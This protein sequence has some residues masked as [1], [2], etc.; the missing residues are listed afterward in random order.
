[1][2]GHFWLLFFCIFYYFVDDTFINNN[3]MLCVYVCVLVLFGQQTQNVNNFISAVIATCNY[4][5]LLLID[6]LQTFSFF[7]C[8]LFFFDNETD[9]TRPSEDFSLTCIGQNSHMLNAC[10]LSFTVYTKNIIIS[11]FALNS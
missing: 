9:C 5:I 8:F 3:I 1:M 2:Q 4:A 11:I 7:F 10:L 6:S